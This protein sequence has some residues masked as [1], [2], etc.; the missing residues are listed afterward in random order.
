MTAS[1]LARQLEGGVVPAQL[2]AQRAQVQIGVETHDFQPGHACEVFP[3]GRGDGLAERRV[4]TATRL[5]PSCREL[6]LDLLPAGG[7]IRV[8]RG[9]F[10]D[11]VQVIWDA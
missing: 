3:L 4:M 5:D 2:V 9:Q 8:A 11:G 6:R 7:I 10:P 1:E